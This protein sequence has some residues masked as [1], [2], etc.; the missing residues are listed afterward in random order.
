M[1]NS[2]QTSSPRTKHPSQDTALSGRYPAIIKTFSNHKIQTHLNWL[3]RFG[4]LSTNP[5]NPT[6]LNNVYVINTNARKRDNPL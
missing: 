4:N 3:N 1:P 6:S 5:I 2:K